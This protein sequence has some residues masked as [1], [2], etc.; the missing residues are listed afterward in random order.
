[1][2]M[3]SELSGDELVRFKTSRLLKRLV[4]LKSASSIATRVRLSS[5]V[6]DDV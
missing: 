5:A 1:M 4:M 3:S 2:S 6:D